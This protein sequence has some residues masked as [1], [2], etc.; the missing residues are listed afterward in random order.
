MVFNQSKILYSSITNKII[1]NNF[2]EISDLITLN[3]SNLNEHYSNVTIN[4]DDKYR[5][6]I[7]NSNLQILRYNELINENDSIFNITNNE[8][9][10]II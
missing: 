6:G 9:I 2:S 8:I 1:L 5:L 4:F 10:S 3:N 7:V